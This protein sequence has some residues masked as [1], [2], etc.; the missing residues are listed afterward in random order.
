MPSSLSTLR[1]CLDH[2]APETWTI[3]EEAAF[4]D[5]KAILLSSAAPPFMS[6]SL[7]RRQVGEL[8]FPLFFVFRRVALSSFRLRTHQ[9]DTLPPPLR[10]DLDGSEGYDES[11]DE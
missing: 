4:E 2:L 9:L 3:L 11:S 1:D 10:S 5:L 8:T 7:S 6:L